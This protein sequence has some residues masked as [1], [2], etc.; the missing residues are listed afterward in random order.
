MRQIGTLN[1]AGRSQREKID[2]NKKQNAI[3]DKKLLG[4]KEYLNIRNKAYYEN[5]KEYDF[6]AKSILTCRSL[7]AI[8]SGLSRAEGI[9][10]ISKEIKE[11]LAGRSE[12]QQLKKQRS[13]KKVMCTLLVTIHLTDC[14]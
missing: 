6:K 12:E 8:I 4:N 5:N 9:H 3:L 14:N 7:Y 11:F 1:I 2:E 10:A 13:H